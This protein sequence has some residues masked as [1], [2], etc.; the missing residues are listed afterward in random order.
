[1]LIIFVI[2]IKNNMI[3]NDNKDFSKILSQIEKPKKDTAELLAHEIIEEILNLMLNKHMHALEDN[4]YLKTR[5]HS[6][7]Y[8]WDG[9]HPR[10]A[11]QMKFDLMDKALRI[12]TPEIANQ[13]KNFCSKNE[14]DIV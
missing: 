10:K 8:G 11:L 13:V 1:M 14:K 9:D 7:G 5:K 4:G 12:F 2:P 3:E 6:K